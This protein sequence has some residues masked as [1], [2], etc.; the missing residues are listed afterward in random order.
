MTAR[1]VPHAKSAQAR[2]KNIA[3]TVDFHAVG[4]A[5]VFAARLFAENPAIRNRSVRLEVARADIALFA[6]VRVEVFAVRRESQA[7]RLREFACK[8]LHPQAILSQ[9]IN[10]LKWKFH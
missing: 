7:A 1:F 10:A 4:H 8:Q 9:A 3:L 2:N 6:V 5:A